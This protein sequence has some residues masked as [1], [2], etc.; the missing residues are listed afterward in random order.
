MINWKEKLG[1]FLAD[2]ENAN[3][4]VGIL[5]CG[6]YI[7][8][9]PTAHSDLDVHI[10]LDDS[11]EYRERGNKIID[12][13]LIE[14]FSNPPRQVLKYFDGDI[15]DK[16]LMS[17]VQFATGEILLDKTGDVKSL[18]EKA[19]KMIE[20]FYKNDTA[21]ISES[22]KYFM[23][24]MLDDL[25]DAHENNKP[26]FDF[27]YYN[28]LNRLISDYMGC[29]NRPYHLKTIFG[30][31]TSEIVRKKYLLRELPDKDIS[32]L[33]VKCISAIGSEEKMESYQNLTTAIIDKFGGFD[34]NGYKIKSDVEK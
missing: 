19:F 13:L 2:F 18:K 9:N 16:S 26:D 34:V 12:G 8:G 29:I 25:Q 28:L 30:N 33:I 21:V 32:D 17:Q 20:D 7:T 31:I 11:V 27:L 15:K 23:W 6:S 14:Y 4:M 3:D 22:I 10:I 5:A 1:I 24:D